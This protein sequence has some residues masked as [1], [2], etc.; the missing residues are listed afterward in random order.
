MICEKVRNKGF[1]FVYYFLP[2]P[3]KQ[4]KI[5]LSRKYLFVLIPCNRVSVLLLLL[6][7]LFRI[8]FLLFAICLHLIL[9]VQKQQTHSFA[10]FKSVQLQIKTCLFHKCLNNEFIIDVRAHTHTDTQTHR[11]YQCD[12]GFFRCC[13]CFCNCSVCVQQTLSLVL[14]EC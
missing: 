14:C 1:F 2:Q 7:L 5:F 12:V 3:F 11:F 13:L 6:F 4:P 10:P 8:C 9:N